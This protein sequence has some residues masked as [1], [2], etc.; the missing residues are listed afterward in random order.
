VTTALTLNPGALEVVVD[1]A[2]HAPLR[3]VAGDGAV[4]Q[5]PRSWVAVR[6]SDG[7]DGVGWVEWNRNL[8][9]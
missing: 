9:R 4:A 5:F 2:A 1:I 3:L 7:R 6:T 8:G